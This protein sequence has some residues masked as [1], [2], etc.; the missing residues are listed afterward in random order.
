MD[1]HAHLQ[2]MKLLHV[3]LSRILFPSSQPDQ[4]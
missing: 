2:G 4:G 1:Q 3:V